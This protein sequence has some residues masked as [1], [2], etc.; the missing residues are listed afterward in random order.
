MVYDNAEEPKMIIDF[1]A[2]NFMAFQS[3]VTFSFEPSNQISRFGTNFIDVS[4][5]KI[6]KTLGVYG[7]NNT[8]K[9]CSI[10]ALKSIR[11][12]LR[13]SSLEDYFRDH[14]LE[15]NW[16]SESS[17]SSFS[18]RFVSNG[19]IYRYSF[20]FD[21]KTFVFL[22]ESIEKQNLDGSLVTLLSFDTLVN[23]YEGSNQKSV[24][25]LKVISH[26]NPM[27]SSLNVDDYPL[28]R[29]AQNDF[30]SFANSLLFF[31]GTGTYN[32]QRTISLLKEGGEGSKDILSFVKGAD[33]NLDDFRYSKKEQETLKDGRAMLSDIP[34]LVSDYHGH[35]VPSYLYDS[36]GS[37]KIE[38]LAGFVI[39]VLRK[40]GTLIVDEID[41]SLFFKVSRAVV[42]AFNNTANEKAQLFFTTH[43]V[44]LMDTKYLLRKDQIYF[45]NRNKETR[46]VDVKRL[47]SF[48]SRKDG[49]RGNEDVAARYRK[50]LLEE[51]PDPDF[52]D[53]LLGTFPSEKIEDEV[54][55]NDAEEDDR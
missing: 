40:G 13:G 2:E 18:I 39:D 50:D 31:G 35:E 27:F 6:L 48:T 20:S 8:G 22:S 30:L 25:S 38:A 49:I 10:D 1:S 28:L 55:T 26:R 15:P 23:K 16:F 9:S 44:S 36:R 32:I 21:F 33:V 53:V 46:L 51:L 42:S 52:L 4:G 19:R 29:D 12:V 14:H 41:A 3:K 24:S 54:E 47:S 17:I 43:D 34:F 11:H 7:P 45:V 37:Q 5:A